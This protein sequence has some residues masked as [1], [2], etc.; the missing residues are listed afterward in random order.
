MTS[1]TSISNAAV[2]VGGIP[3]SATVTALRDNPSALAEG[4]SGAPVMVSG[5]HPVDKVTIGDGK[6]GLI[7]D[8]AVNGTQANVTSPN[9]E[10]GY[11]YRIFGVNISHNDANPR[12]LIVELFKQ[13]SASW[14]SIGTFPSVSSGT[15]IYF[16]VEIIMPRI[17]G[18]LHFGRAIFGS[19]TSSSNIAGAATSG[20]FEKV[21]NA[22][23]RFAAGSIDS[24]GIWLFRRREYASSP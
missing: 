22:R 11:E 7:Y 23:I 8:F 21:L 16:D 12:S 6:T 18:N 3:S 19:S 9:F 10:D 2:A 17:A 15:E 5:W 1:W 24:G 20:S 13:T 4:V 14:V